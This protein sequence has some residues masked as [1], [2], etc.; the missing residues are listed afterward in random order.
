MAG[1]LGCPASG[2]DTIVEVRR[3]D[4]FTPTGTPISPPQLDG[5][6]RLQGVERVNYVRTYNAW[7]PFTV[8]LGG[9]SFCQNI[10]QLIEPGWWEVR[11]LRGRDVAYSGVIYEISQTSG[12]QSAQLTGGDMAS[13]FAEDGGRLINLM[14]MQFTDVDPVDAAAEVIR[15][16]FG[17]ITPPD[18]YLMS[19]YL[20][21]NP[22]GETIDYAP[23]V[24]ADYVLDTLDDFTEFG[25]LYAAVGRRIILA[26]PATL[27]NRP[28][29]TL[30]TAHFDGPVRLVKS[31]L[32]MGVLGVAVGEDDDGNTQVTTYGDT[33]SRWGTPS[34]RVDVERGVSARSRATAAR[35]AIQGKTRPLYRV[36]MPTSARLLPT[37]P[38][39]LNN[40]RP[41]S[42][43]VD[44]EVHDIPV[45]VR[46]PAMLTE[47]EFEWRGGRED[48]KAT[49]AP[50][51][52]PV[53]IP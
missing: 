31:S 3:L 36:D 28:V 39:S 50:I 4:R 17:W 45:P 49:L 30:T 20:Y 9:G 47:V 21:T 25:L 41:G 40:L 18:G 7:G 37:A 6:F 24:T 23:G 16:A 34:I 53:A 38:I 15:Y 1:Y 44:M 14:D 8:D 2:D 19:D 5:Y 52:A 43:R 22:I 13:I 51:G 29:A 46:Q 35:R 12:Q 48:I 27:A 11:I 32:D 33:G 26:Q 10:L 42:A